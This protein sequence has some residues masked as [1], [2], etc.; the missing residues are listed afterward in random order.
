MS[1][2]LLVAPAVCA[3][4]SVGCFSLSRDSNRT[5]PSNAVAELL[6]GQWATTQSLPGLGSIQETCTDFTWSVTDFSGSS[7]S[8]TFSATCAGALKVNGTAR[9][10]LSGTT[11]N[12]TATATG[13]G[14]GVPN[15]CAISLAGTAVFDGNVIRIPYTGSTC[16]GTQLS[17]T[18]IIGKR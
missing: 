8:G 16:L 12:W 6:G 13:S 11:V 17:G 14:P 18:E 1:R 15:A 2:K 3:L 10:T 7:A 4:I 5:G 9:G